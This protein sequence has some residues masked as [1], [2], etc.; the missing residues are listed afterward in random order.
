MLHEPPT[1]QCR[2]RQDDEQDPERFRG[3]PGDD[4]E[5]D[6][7]ADNRQGGATLAVD[8]SPPDERADGRQGAASS[9]VRSR[10]EDDE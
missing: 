1:G 10:D 5:D 7:G 3:D 8:G 4:P 9:A 6:A 2:D